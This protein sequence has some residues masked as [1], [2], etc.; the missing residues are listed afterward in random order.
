MKIEPLTGLV[1]AT[2]TSLRDDGSPHLDRIPA[3]VDYF[4][5][6]VSALEG[7]VFFDWGRTPD[8]G[9]ALDTAIPL[10]GEDRP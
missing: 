2:F 7:T 6:G 8:V 5:R 4:E 9:N 3:V 10:F 1:A